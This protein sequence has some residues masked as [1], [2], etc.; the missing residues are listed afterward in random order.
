MR[1][2]DGLQIE[3]ADER[4]EFHESARRRR[5]ESMTTDYTDAHGLDS[6]SETE[7]EQKETKG[8]K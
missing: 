4:H 6:E 2:T 5:T 7:F 1:A 8:T 3:K